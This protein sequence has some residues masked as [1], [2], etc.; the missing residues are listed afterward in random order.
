VLLHPSRAI[1]RQH[2]VSRLNTLDQSLFG[3]RCRTV[4]LNDGLPLKAGIDKERIGIR[5]PFQPQME[6]MEDEQKNL[7]KD[8]PQ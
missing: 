8:G 5:N 3:W 7:S 6:S 4:M 2:A 1:D